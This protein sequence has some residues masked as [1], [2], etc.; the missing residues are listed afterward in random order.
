M[1]SS[2][3]W[4]A[5]ADEFGDAYARVLAQDLVLSAVGGQTAM[6][7]LRDG[8]APKQIWLAVCDAQDVPVSR[9][10]GVGLREPGR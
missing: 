2:E 4:Q 7:A 3:F 5:M 1:R 6:E 10:H 8:V 9:R